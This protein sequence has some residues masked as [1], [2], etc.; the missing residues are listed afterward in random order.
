[1]TAGDARPGGALREL[2][3]AECLSRLAGSAIGRIA[4]C[5][6]DGPVIVPVNFVLD[7][8]TVVLRTAP[9]TWL[10][11]H[12]SD[13]TAFEVDDLDDEMRRGWSVIIVGPASI[14][15]DVDEVV[16][17]DLRSR[18]RPWAPG[19]RNMFIRI[20]PRRITGREVSADRSSTDELRG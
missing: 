19:S 12:V 11:G 14:V 6:P 18:L 17:A 20:T 1:M 15:E 8:G 10:A 16:D 7:R 2:S 3:D 9:Y 4:V 13:Q 5:T